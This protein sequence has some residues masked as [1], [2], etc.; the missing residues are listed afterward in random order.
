MTAIM[1]S[2]QND[3][4]SGVSNTQYWENLALVVNLVSESKALLFV[5]VGGTME[6]CPASTFPG[7]MTWRSCFTK[8]VKILTVETA[9]KPGET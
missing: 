4:V 1:F 2:R 3:A 9:T 5:S 6:N 7:V 8:F